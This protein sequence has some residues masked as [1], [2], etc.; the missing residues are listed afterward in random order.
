MRLSTAVAGVAR[1]PQLIRFAVLALVLA[2]T[3]GLL[4][5]WSWGQ[6]VTVDPADLPTTGV[7]DAR[8]EGQTRATIAGQDD[9]TRLDWRYTAIRPGPR[10]SVSR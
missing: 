2:L 8:P 6:T 9:V 7:V 5:D 3:I 4:S 1:V 10:A